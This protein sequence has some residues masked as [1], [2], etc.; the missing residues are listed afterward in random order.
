M[1]GSAPI[2]VLVIRDHLA[3]AGGTTY[4]LETLPQFDPARVRP[5]LC[6]LQ[7]RCPVACAFEAAG[8]RPV[9][10]PRRT[11]DPRGLLDLWR[12]VRA[13]RPDLLFLSG[14]KSNLRGR[15]VARWSRVPAIL[16]FNYMLP[17]APGVALLQRRLAAS[18]AAAVA[19]SNAVQQWASRQYGLPPQRIRVIYEGRNVDRFAAPAP[20]ARSRIR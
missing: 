20:A 3:P 4:L 15:L 11:R 18:T 2:K 17:E 19:V 12:L 7:P 1:T 8:I 10:L 16:R 5:A 6:V 13:E 9:F 14:P